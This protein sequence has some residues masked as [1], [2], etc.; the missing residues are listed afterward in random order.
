MGPL[1]RRFFFNILEKL[2]EICD[3][4]KT[5]ADKSQSLEIL[6]KLRKV[7]YVMNVQNIDR[8]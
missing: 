5:L 6:K 8:Y 3:S 4:L 1:I 2:R 7:R